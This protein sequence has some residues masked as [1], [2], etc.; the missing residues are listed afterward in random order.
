MMSNDFTQGIKR[1]CHKKLLNSCDFVLLV[2][3]EYFTTNQL[4]LDSTNVS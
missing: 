2:I 1:K 3:P 4:N